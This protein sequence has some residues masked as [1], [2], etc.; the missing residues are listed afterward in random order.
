MIVVGVDEAGRGP[1]AGPVVAGAVILNSENP[2]EGLADSKKLSLK[3]REALFELIWQKALS[4]GVGVATEKEID[5]M[6]ILQASLLA[7]RRAVNNLSIKPDK[8]MV[9]GNQDPGL[10][11]PTETIV[12]GDSLIPAISAGS[13]IAK[14]TRDRMMAEIDKQFPQYGFAKHAG[15][16]TKAHVAAI[17]EHGP[18]VFHR[19]SFRPLKP[20]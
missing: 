15:Y 1:L 16:P 12:K 7:M 9:D 17:S 5:E 13:I 2:I 19:M 20:A 6:N 8:A 18:C 3:K 4:V 14:V 11:C 10:F